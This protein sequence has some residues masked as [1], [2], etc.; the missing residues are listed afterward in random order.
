MTLDNVDKAILS[1]LID[2]SRLSYRQ[3]AKKVGVSVAT[4]M[5]RVKALEKEG[6]IRRYTTLL[7]YEKLG[8]DVEVMIEVRIAKGKLIEVEK[9]IA[10][11][12]SVFAVYDM[13]G[14]F[15]A[16]I[17]ARFTNRRKMDSFLKK[18]QTL[19]FV[20]RTN[21][22]FILNTIREKQVGVM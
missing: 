3:I 1:T 18:I 6:I 14:D 11:N 20:E 12:P 10:S 19:D 16:V 17:L 8:Y 4:A 2:D 7:N 15:D 21:T 22:R 9:Q 5:N 13:T